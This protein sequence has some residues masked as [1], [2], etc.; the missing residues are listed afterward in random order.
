LQERGQFPIEFIDVLAGFAQQP[1]RLTKIG[2]TGVLRSPGVRCRVGQAPVDR[3]QS[4][5]EL[6]ASGGG[7]GILRLYRIEQM[8]G[9]GADG[10]DRGSQRRKAGWSPA[11]IS[12]DTEI[13]QSTGDEES[14]GMGKRHVAVVFSGL[15]FNDF[16]ADRGKQGLRRASY[17]GMALAWTQ[18][19]AQR[20]GTRDAERAEQGMA[21][22]V[23]DDVA[24]NTA[25][26]MVFF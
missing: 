15:L 21:A 25:D 8:P 14:H 1:R 18:H 23:A 20:V 7:V 26:D 19:G 17:V 11:Q 5:D 16:D 10:G 2:N 12:I 24:A 3:C 6:P 9:I 13:D 22:D 4:L